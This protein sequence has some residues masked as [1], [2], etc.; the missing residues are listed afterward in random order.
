MAIRS[1][2]VPMIE[3]TIARGWLAPECRAFDNSLV[4]D[5]CEMRGASAVA[6]YLRALG[7]PAI[8][9]E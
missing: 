9:R 1:N 3:E 2:S 6:D 5:Y 4:I 8:E 7:W